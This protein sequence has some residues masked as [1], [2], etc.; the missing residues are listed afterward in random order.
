MENGQKQMDSIYSH[1]PKKILNIQIKN[2]K[3][4]CFLQSKIQLH[5][6]TELNNSP[7]SSE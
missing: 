6:L 1:I 3:I 4:F 5:P 2:L 7:Y